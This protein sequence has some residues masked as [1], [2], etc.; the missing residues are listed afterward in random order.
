VALDSPP[1][2]P[3]RDDN[4]CDSDLDFP[5]H[6]IASEKERGEGEEELGVKKKEV[7][8]KVLVWADS[9]DEIGDSVGSG[10]EREEEEE[11][12]KEKEEEEEDE[13]DEKQDHGD[14]SA[15]PL[16]SRIFIDLTQGSPTP[17][18]TPTHKQRHGEEFDLPKGASKLRSQSTATPQKTPGLF[19]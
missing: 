19:F 18:P 7:A 17:S 13:D 8:R 15:T 12:K 4:L 2:S 10:L 6:S 3:C 1:S 14:V 16:P 9:D 11:E 5:V